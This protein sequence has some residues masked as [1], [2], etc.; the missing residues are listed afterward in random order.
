MPYTCHFQIPSHVIT[1]FNYNK[2]LEVGATI[3]PILKITNDPCLE[4]GRTTERTVHLDH[5]YLG[6]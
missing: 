6:A 3:F 1:S 5:F 2:T 4:W